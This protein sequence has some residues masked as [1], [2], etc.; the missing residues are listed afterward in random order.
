MICESVIFIGSHA[1]KPKQNPEV[2]EFLMKQF[3]SYP[4]T[5]VGCCSL[6]EDIEAETV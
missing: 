6:L 2:I 5:S 1:K 4:M 3:D